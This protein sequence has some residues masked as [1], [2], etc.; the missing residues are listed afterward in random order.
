MPVI[1]PP[2]PGSAQPGGQASSPA[3]EEWCRCSEAVAPC[4]DGVFHAHGAAN[5]G[6]RVPR[7]PAAARNLPRCCPADAQR[8]RR[9]RPLGA[10]E[11]AHVSGRNAQGHS[12]S[13]HPADGPHRLSSRCAMLAVKPGRKIDREPE[14]RTEGC[15]REPVRRRHGTFRRSRDPAAGATGRTRSRGFPAR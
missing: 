3:A 7:P 13:P 4:A 12:P 10:C 9:V 5:F 14:R 15:R 2:S 1:G 8:S 11:A 6:V